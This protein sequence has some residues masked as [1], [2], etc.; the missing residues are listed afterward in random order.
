MS[1]WVLCSCPVQKAMFNRVPIWWSMV[2]AIFL[3][4]PRLCSWNLAEGCKFRC[5]VYG[6]ASHKQLFSAFWT[7]VSCWSGLSRRAPKQYRPLWQLIISICH[8]WEPPE[9]VVSPKNWPGLLL[10]KVGSLTLIV[11]HL[12]VASQIKSRWQKDGEP[13]FCLLGLPSCPW[14]NS[15]WCLLLV[16]SQISE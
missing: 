8:R 5:P 14:V 4:L 1:S 10:I 3:V 12:L 2:F 7:V 15:P 16:F 11:G 6:W 9:Y 13:T